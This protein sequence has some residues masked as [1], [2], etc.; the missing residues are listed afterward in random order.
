MRCSAGVRV[1][2]TILA[3]SAVPAA[4]AGADGSAIA[5]PK[6]T[7]SSIIVGFVG[8]LVRHDNL[9]H[10]P[11]QLAKRLLNTAPEGTYIRVFEN[12]RRKTAF[13]T[14]LELLDRNHDGILSDEEKSEARIVLFGQ[15]W[16][17]AAV[18]Q[19]AR[20]LSRA[21][22]P[23]LLTVQVDSVPKFWQNDKIIPKNVA[24]AVNF[25]QPHGIVHGQPEITAA[26]PSRTQILGN[27]RFDYKQAP[28]T[29]PAPSWYDRVFTPG[30]AQTECDPQLWSQVETLVRQ[31]LKLHPGTA[32]AQR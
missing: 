25:Y 24:A 9:R 7:S 3:I 5:Q 16:G 29:C 19:L 14:I 32:S 15:S 10:G 6:E 18:V 12:R 1:L 26:D 17:A 22:I 21:G 8:G 20:D 4:L 30:H 2:A 31:R 23:V 13:D 11:V 27:F 28:A